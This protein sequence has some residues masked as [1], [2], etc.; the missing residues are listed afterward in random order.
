[1][2][3]D[4]IVSIRD[5]GSGEII[6]DLA[7]FRKF[8]EFANWVSFNGTELGEW[9]YEIHAR[10]WEELVEELEPIVG[11]FLSKTQKELTD[12]EEEGIN[13]FTKEEI[14]LFERSLINPL[15]ARSTFF[16]QKLK[17]LY[18][19]AITASEILSDW[20]G[21]RYTITVFNSF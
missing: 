16:V 19:L 18:G 2:G 12:L 17:R 3:L 4:T 9:N 1:M 20:D 7:N 15:S 10:R 21:A 5:S 6:L 8:H 11:V 14:D 13:P